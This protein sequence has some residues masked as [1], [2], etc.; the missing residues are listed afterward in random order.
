MGGAKLKRVWTEISN[1]TWLQ[2]SAATKWAPSARQEQ[3]CTFVGTSL[4]GM[5]SPAVQRGM[6]GRA[7]RTALAGTCSQAG[8][9][10]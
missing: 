5:G 8:H 6:R 9:D 4:R 7:L 1:G 10:Q 2:D 3:D